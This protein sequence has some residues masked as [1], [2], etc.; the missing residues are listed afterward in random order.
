MPRLGVAGRVALALFGVLLLA[1]AGVFGG[2]PT[3]NELEKREQVRTAASTDATVLSTNV[4]RVGGDSRDESDS[5]DYDVRVT[6]EYTAGGETYTSS[7]VEPPGSAGAGAVRVD[8]MA[9]AES[10]TAE[11]GANGTVTAYY[12][13]ERPSTSFLEQETV[14]LVALAIPVGF[15]LLPAG[16]GLF[17]LAIAAGVVDLGGY[18]YGPS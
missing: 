17:L 15:A 13:P 11:Y 7:A 12:L 14:P 8:T 18:R 4:S 1:V 16:V 6:Y 2:L 10:L 5:F 9:E 3:L